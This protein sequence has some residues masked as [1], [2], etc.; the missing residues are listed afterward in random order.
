M[1]F[2]RGNFGDI[3]KPP[4]LQR[5]RLRLK[6]RLDLGYH[7]NAETTQDQSHSLTDSEHLVNKS[8]IYICLSFLRGNFG[9]KLKTPQLQMQMSSNSPLEFAKK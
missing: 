1:P 7:T 9:D 3:L 5:L 4:Q 8:M 6:T 2:L